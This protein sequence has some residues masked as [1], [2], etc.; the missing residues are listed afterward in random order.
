MADEMS[1]GGARYESEAIT[2]FLDELYGREDEAMRQA[3]A[4]LERPGI[5]AIQVSARDGATLALLMRLANA[6][7]VV[8]IGTLTGYSA[9]WLLR[10]M[11]AN[12]HLWTLEANPVHAA[13]ARRVLAGEGDRVTVL[14]GPALATLPGLTAHGPFDAV[15]IDA[16]KV[17]YAAYGRWALDHLRPGGLVVADNAYVFGYLAGREPDARA[18]AEAIAAVRA[19]HEMLAAECSAA[20]TLSTADGLAVGVKA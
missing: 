4:E 10:G 18:S 5:P 19:L 20:V 16:D 9:L 14:E 13:A 1:R 17:G 15:F 8:E 11:A 6:R 2:A 3:L 7:R 12:G